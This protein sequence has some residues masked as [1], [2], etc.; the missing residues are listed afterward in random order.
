MINDKDKLKMRLTE[1][2][3][4]EY[5]TKYYWVEK[6]SETWYNYDCIRFKTFSFVS[7]NKLN[8][9]LKNNGLDKYFK[10]NKLSCYKSRNK[11]YSL[12]LTS[13]NDALI[14]LFQLKGMIL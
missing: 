12:T 4:R 3:Y 10:F 2:C 9:L 5:F 7:A 6:N 11:S 14:S 8:Q 1:F 13:Y